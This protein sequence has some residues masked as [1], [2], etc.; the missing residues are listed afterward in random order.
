MLAVFFYKELFLGQVFSPADLLLGSNPW[1]AYRPPTFHAASNPLRSDEALIGY[2]HRVDMANDV[3]AFGITLWQDHTLGGSPQ[4]YAVHYLGAWVYPPALV[5]LF[6]GGAAANTLMYLTIPLYAGISMY[7]FSSLLTHHR[8][9]RAFGAIAFALNGY[10]TVWLSAFALPVIVATLPLSLYLGIRFL[11]DKR[12]LFGILFSLS[13]GGIFYLAY[14]PA[15]IIYAAVLAVFLVAYWAADPGPRT[16]PLLQL[17]GLG[18]I[19]VGL[20]AAAGLPTIAELSHL[21]GTAYRNPDSPI[22]LHFLATFIYPNFFGNPIAN[23]WRATIGNYCE[24]IA[25]VGA[26]P[27]MLS[28]P[29]LLLGVVRRRAA[30]FVIGAVTIGVLA[31]VLAYV[32]PVVSVLNR[33][34]ILYGV[35][36]ARWTVGIDLAVIILA[37]IGLDSLLTGPVGRPQLVALGATLGLFVLGASG[38]VLVSHGGLLHQDAFIVRDVWLR[39]ALIALGATALACLAIFS[40]FRWALAPVLVLILAVDL[41]SF[42][43]QFNPAIPTAEFYPTTP[44]L[45]FLEQHAANYRV[46]PVGGLL[47]TDDVSTYGLDVITGYDHFRNDRY[48][49][50]LGDNLSASE[51]A[52]W[53]KSGFVII[54]DQPHLESDLFSMLAVKFAYFPQKPD[55]RTIAAWQHWR[56][57]YSGPDGAVLENLAVLRKQFLV[58]GLTGKPRSIDHAAVGPDHDQLTVDGGGTLVWAK[59]WEK[60]WTVSVDG[61][62]AST[63]PYHGYFLSVVLPP[64]RHVVS[65]TFQPGIYL[66]GVIASALSLLV[67]LS[68]AL[69]G[70][71]SRRAPA[72]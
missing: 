42:G 50:L 53:S 39:L 13:L 16:V 68:L 64:G 47:Y 40:N 38:G 33:L 71:L 59:P 11:R 27:L 28:G 21:N 19:G 69:G 3:R 62:P 72:C 15:I 52:L 44:A 7:L 66:I 67:L 1:Q 37:V 30:P 22:P 48:V 24:D 10:S 70:G 55:D 43:F 65:I 49:A 57:A 18:V 20:G 9:A 12:M 14:P 34:P 8:W 6:L 31:V 23:D 35:N 60:D 51:R 26:L 63:Q 56:V 25:Y 17:V 45:R 29:A 4:S 61:R 46:L 54:S 36:P 58:A 41:V 2:P 32:G 5:F